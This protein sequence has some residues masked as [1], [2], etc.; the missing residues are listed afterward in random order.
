MLVKVVWKTNFYC[1]FIWPGWHSP[2]MH[3]CDLVTRVNHMSIKMAE[4]TCVEQTA[5]FL[6][7]IHVKMKWHK[8]ILNLGMG[9]ARK[10][11]S[12]YIVIF[13]KRIAIRIVIFCTLFVWL[14]PSVFLMKNLI[15]ALELSFIMINCKYYWTKWPDYK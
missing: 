9:I 10:N 8:V 13:Y 7:K 6:K 14:V 5:F 3:L 4:G 1:L 2:R 11:V 15:L 12:R